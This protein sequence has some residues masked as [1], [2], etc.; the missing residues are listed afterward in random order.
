MVVKWWC[1]NLIVGINY[2]FLL[3]VYIIGTYSYKCFWFAHLSSLEDKG[4]AHAYTHTHAHMHMHIYN[5]DFN[6]VV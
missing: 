5:S 1:G 2:D 3:P 6:L 4:C